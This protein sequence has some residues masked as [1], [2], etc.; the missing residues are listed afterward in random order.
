[1][2]QESVV[3]YVM[4]QFDVVIDFSCT[5]ISILHAVVIFDVQFERQKVDKKANLH[6]N[7]NLQ[8]LF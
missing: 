1:M 7:W 8:T 3:G 2:L 5:V 6:E 4:S